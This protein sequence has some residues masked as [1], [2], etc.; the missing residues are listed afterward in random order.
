MFMFTQLVTKTVPA[1][2]F[3]YGGFYFPS[4][5]EHCKDVRVGQLLGQN[6][7]SGGSPEWIVQ[8]PVSLPALFTCLFC[9][10]CSLQCVQD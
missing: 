2:A 7:G 5:L 6:R 3:W 8:V 4:Y 1:E 9:S 10:V